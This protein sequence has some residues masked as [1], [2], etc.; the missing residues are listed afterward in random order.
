MGLP[1][2]LFL[3]LLVLKL[4]HVI[5]VSW[6]V[7]FLPLAPE[8]LIDLVIIGLVGAKWRSMAREDRARRAR[9]RGRV[10]GVR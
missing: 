2:A 3:V 7:V 4:T 8:L 9:I 5:A 10:R 1:A 6:W